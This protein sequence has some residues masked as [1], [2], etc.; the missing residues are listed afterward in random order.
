MMQCNDME[1]DSCLELLQNVQ[2]FLI[3]L[4][5]DGSINSKITASGLVECF[6]GSGCY[7][8]EVKDFNRTL[9]FFLKSHLL[10][11]AGSIASL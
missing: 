4:K 9:V 1:L 6:D 2:E 7:V 10:K 8:S 3:Q 5:A 11:T